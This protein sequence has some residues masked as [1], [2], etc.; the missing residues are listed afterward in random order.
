M[1][2]YIWIRHIFLKQNYN[3]KKTEFTSC[4]YVALFTDE[5]SKLKDDSVT[6]RLFLYV[7][8]AGDRIIPSVH[9]CLQELTYKLT[10]PNIIILSVQVE[11]Q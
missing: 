4:I 9:K 8:E 1:Y 2:T 7:C 11:G 5:Q 3:F 6:N 10:E